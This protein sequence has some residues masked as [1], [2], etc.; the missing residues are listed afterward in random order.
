MEQLRQAL[1]IHG[2]VLPLC[3][4]AL[5]VRL[6]RI[7]IPSKRLR[8]RI[9]HTIYGKK[10]APLD[11]SEAELPL[12]AYPSLNAL[13]TRGLR[14]ETRPIPT[15]PDTFLSPCDG[16]VQEVGA[17]E[18]DR[19]VTAK[20]IEYTT[21][22]LLATSDGEVFHGGQFAIIFL[23]PTDC[24]RIFR[25]QDGHL[26]EITH[27]PGCRLLVHPPYQRKEYPVY[28]LNER[29][30]LRFRTPHG[31]CALVLVAGWGVGNITL[32]L[33]RGYRPRRRLTAKIYDPPVQVSRGDWIATF[34]LGSTAIL[35]TERAVP[36]TPCVMGNEK[37]KY[38]QRLLATQA[39]ARTP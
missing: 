33:D 11:E 27:V 6:S 35:I 31:A 24:H 13:F 29:V 10:Y 7:H 8:L 25:P 34:E 2:G 16:T 4:A 1:R 39:N 28:A 20:G 5:A 3:A 21:R 14:P 9:Y 23:S 17:L 30:I 38:G 19:I 37:V 32:P 18:R 26:E 15:D 12:W 36:C 22:S